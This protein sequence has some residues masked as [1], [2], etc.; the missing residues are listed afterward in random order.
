[1]TR[2]SGTW[3]WCTMS[4]KFS[5]VSNSTSNSSTVLEVTHQT[6]FTFRRA[7][8]IRSRSNPVACLCVLAS[9]S[10]APSSFAETKRHAATKTRGL[11]G[12]A[13][14]FA[15]WVSQKRLMYT[16]ALST[17]E[18]CHSS[19]APADLRAQNAN[20]STAC[21]SSGSSEQPLRMRSS[22]ESLSNH[23]RE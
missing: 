9:F 18:M 11:F 16:T 2:F 1:M 8:V 20:R 7:L 15:H 21:L 19:A 22:S 10:F 14:G 23:R 5:A 4:S 17:I 13:R 12:L 6:S 3:T